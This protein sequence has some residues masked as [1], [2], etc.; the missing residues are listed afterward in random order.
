MGQ[1]DIWHYFWAGMD[2]CTIIEGTIK[3]A[4]Y[5]TEYTLPILHVQEK[6][7]EFTC[8]YKKA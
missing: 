7:C 5:L 8:R 2:F 6:M 4:N 3:I 1:M